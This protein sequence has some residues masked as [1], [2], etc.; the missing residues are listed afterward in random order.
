[1]DDESVRR[2]AAFDRIRR[3]VQLPRALSEAFVIYGVLWSV[4]FGVGYRSSAGA[5][6][7]LLYGSVG[8][9]LA[10]LTYRS[11]RRR[12]V[13]RRRVV[14][15]AEPVPCSIEGTDAIAK[16]SQ[17]SRTALA[18]G[19]QRFLP[20]VEFTYE[21]DGDE[22][23]S[24]DDGPLDGRDVPA[25]AATEERAEQ[26]AAA[27]VEEHAA[28]PHRHGARPASGERR[29][30]RAFPDGV[31]ETSVGRE[32]AR[33]DARSLAEEAGDTA[34]YDPRT[35]QAFLFDDPKVGV[36]RR[37]ATA[38]GWSLLGYVLLPTLAALAL[39]L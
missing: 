25:R 23:R 1:M 21:L 38:V 11:V 8:V 19:R 30:Y 22:G 32:A 27:V 4:V 24:D 36:Y 33:E 28:N 5:K 17:P 3:R 10:W 12:L 29:S 39:S 35:D 26:L 2:E 18:L 9:A 13:R 20:V 6:P 14:D 37:Q 7:P 16:T 31:H 34:Y 15:R